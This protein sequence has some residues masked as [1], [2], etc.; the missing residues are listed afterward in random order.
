MVKCIDCGRYQPKKEYK[1]SMG[2]IS[3]GDLVYD[4]PNIEFECGYDRPIK[5]EV[6]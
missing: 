5:E 2:K 6:K 1:C 4:D 3:E